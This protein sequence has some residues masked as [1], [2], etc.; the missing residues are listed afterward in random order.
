MAHHHQRR[1]PTR[2]S[3]PA[4]TTEQI[5]IPPLTTIAPAIF[6]PFDTD[7]LLGP[8]VQPATN[9]LEHLQARLKALENN[10][11]RVRANM[12][13]LY[14]REARRLLQDAAEAERQE[15]E[16]N[17]GQVSDNGGGPDAQTLEN[18]LEEMVANMTAEVPAGGEGGRQRG[19]N[20]PFSVQMPPNFT[21]VTP[22]STR[23][24]WLREVMTTLGAGLQDLK[25]YEE[26]I[27]AIRKE[28]TDAINREMASMMQTDLE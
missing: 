28:Y 22:G 24:L 2:G 14:R 19:D 26:H 11:R 25:G 17:G 4:S 8:H 12:L 16:S 5:P 6:I 10:R 15:A 7:D 18:E 20:V 9:N 3:E 23:E 21:N 13:A 27:A 1:Q